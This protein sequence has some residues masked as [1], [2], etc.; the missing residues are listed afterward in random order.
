MQ[1]RV[2][3]VGAGPAGLFCSYLLLKKN[4]H[5]DL[6]DHSSG[7]GKKF[8]IAGNGGLNLTHSEDLKSFAAR[9]GKDEQIFSEL[10]KEFGPDDLRVF[11]SELGV[12]TFVGSS[13]RV[14]PQKLK[15]AQIL[16]NWIKVLK[17]NPNFKLYLKHSLVDITKNKEL[18]FKNPE[19]KVAISADKVILALGGTSWK[20]TGSDGEWKTLLDKFGVGTVAFRPMNCGFE[21]PWSEHFINTVGRAPLKNVEV[22]FK[23]K[24]SRGE[25]MMTPYGL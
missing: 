15:A 9:Y 4:F 20:K 5:V 2:V 17:E 25:V 22:F 7:V 18:V 10:L 1:K 3:V 19:T 13:G 8:L 6:Y 21:R 23:D 24:S 16:L 11:C 14:F 12:D